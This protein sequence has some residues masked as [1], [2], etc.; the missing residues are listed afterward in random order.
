MSSRQLAKAEKSQ[1]FDY[2]RRWAHLDSVEPQE[3]KIA[4]DVYTNMQRRMEHYRQLAL[5]IAFGFLAIFSIVD[6][7][8]FKSTTETRGVADGALMFI[9]VVLTVHMA[10]YLLRMVRKNFTE[11]GATIQRIEQWAGLIGRSEIIK[12]KSVLPA[13]WPTEDR[14]RNRTEGR[15]R[16]WKD[17]IIPPAVR[18][19]F[20]VGLVHG[21]YIAWIY[22]P[23]FGRALLSKVCY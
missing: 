10:G 20:L 11:S 1:Q 12:G 16:S 21:L 14:R 8:M 4:M 3:I 17:D 2:G 5:T 22:G 15:L 7:A 18:I 9:L 13:D 6:T 19:V 23:V